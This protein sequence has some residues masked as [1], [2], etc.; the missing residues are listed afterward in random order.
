MYRDMFN[1][2]PIFTHEQ[3]V[4]IDIIRPDVQLKELGVDFTKATAARLVAV[5]RHG[6][7]KGREFAKAWSRF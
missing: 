5:Y 1:I 7:D 2:E 3:G 6:R 4:P